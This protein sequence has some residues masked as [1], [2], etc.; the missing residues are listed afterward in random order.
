MRNELREKLSRSDL[1]DVL[2]P[3]GLAGSS[4][5][6]SAQSSQQVQENGVGS[7]SHGVQPGIHEYTLNAMGLSVIG[8][9]L[10]QPIKSHCW[11]SQMWHPAKRQCLGEYH[12][13]TIE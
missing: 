9:I 3:Q 1:G 12:V 8:Q 7:C 10:M 4:Q 13:E 2:F 5:R 6:R 11:T